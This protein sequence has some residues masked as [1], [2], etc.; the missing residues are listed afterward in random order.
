MDFGSFG[1]FIDNT[2]GTNIFGQN[3][4]AKAVDAQT[5]AADKADA[6]Q[7]YMYDQTRADLAPWRQAGAQALSQMQDPNFQ[8][9]FS[10]S[11]FQQDPG[12][13]FQLSEGNKAIN[14]AAAARGM[15]NSGA[16]MK[17][18]TAYGQNMAN[19]SYND[20]YN[21]YNNNQT[22]NFNRL[23]TLAGL[24][25]GANNQQVAS[26]ANFGNQ[27]S[28]NQLGVGNAQA[29]G[30]MGQGQQQGAFVGQLYKNLNTGLGMAGGGGG[31]G[32]MFSDER[33]KTDLV[34]VSKEDLAE[35]KSELKAFG[36]KYKD[37]MHGDGP[38]IGV[39][40]QDLEKTKFG[41]SLVFENELGQKQ[42]HL[43][44]LLSLFLATM[45]EG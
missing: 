4:N 11:D 32:G 43:Q 9:N 23:S 16:T 22:N 36:F 24:G 21:R 3:S 12:Y 40:A 41:A 25:S 7:Q 28:Q 20:A 29:A 15:G 35:M 18:L 26:S 14:A 39:M 13:Q 34:P 31:G 6:T 10:M 2:L 37:E 1:G 33:L 44:K 19:Q 5:A 45:A 17:A 42:I 27:I 30:Y 8:K 38:W